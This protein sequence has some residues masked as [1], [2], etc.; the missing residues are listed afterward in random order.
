MNLRT[1]CLILALAAALAAC[2]AGGQT[3]QQRSLLSW[4][5][6][7]SDELIAGLGPPDSRTALANGETMLQYR[8]TRSV[9]QG[10]YTVSM[11]GPAYQNGMGGI[12]PFTGS[13]AD[14][15]RSYVPTQ[16]IQQT[17]IARFTL[18][19]DNRVRQVGWEGDSCN[20]SGT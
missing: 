5:G 8:W 20:L 13:N 16:R 10:G 19:D 9:T 14:L 2:N 3:A 11:G 4:Q 1:A 17:C 6:A 18:G 12:G 7:T 15:P